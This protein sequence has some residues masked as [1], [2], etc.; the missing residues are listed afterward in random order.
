MI[1]RRIEPVPKHVKS[2]PFTPEQQEFLA[3]ALAKQ[4]SARE[5]QRMLFRKF[6]RD[7]SIS[8]IL[9]HWSKSA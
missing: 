4:F 3:E 9:S 5:A 8:G 6:G 2:V 1:V 7:A